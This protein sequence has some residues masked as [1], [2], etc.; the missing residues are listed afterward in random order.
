MAHNSSHT[1]SHQAAEHIV[2]WLDGKLLPLL[3]PP[4]LGPYA[5]ADAPAPEHAICPLCG[6]RMVLH[7]IEREGAHAFLHCPDPAVTVVAES[8]R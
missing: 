5:D 7:E 2:E 6:M 1:G 3:G 4:P 8:G